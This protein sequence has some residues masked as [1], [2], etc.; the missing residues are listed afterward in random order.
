MGKVLPRIL[1]VLI[2]VF[3][4]TLPSGILCW[5]TLY[6]IGTERERIVEDLK[7]SYGEVLREVLSEAQ[8]WY[9]AVLDGFGEDELENYK[10]VRKT[11]GFV[12]ASIV[13]VGGKIVFPTSGLPYGEYP[14]ILG[15]YD[16]GAL[17]SLYEAERRRDVQGL[18][19]V[20]GTGDR[21]KREVA[22]FA[23]ARLDSGFRNQLSG[24][25][26]RLEGVVD[27]EAA[28]LYLKARYLSESGNKE[29]AAVISASLVNRLIQSTD[30]LTYSEI[31]YYVL[32]VR[33]LLEESRQVLGRILV[34]EIE[35][36]LERLDL[37]ERWAEK[38][39]IVKGERKVEKGI[40][41]VEK[42]NKQYWLFYNRDSYLREH[43]W[44]VLSGSFGGPVVVAM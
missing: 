44:R 42:G 23:L 8:K 40:V 9:V 10:K 26:E 6:F 1:P 35:S 37:M 25:V 13:T 3:V 24:E 12:E 43:I 4:I 32:F 22:K 41:E 27:A 11:S 14:G 16:Y 36:A 18:K 2:V 28:A 39:S 29:A 15:G 31:R 38:M 21:H 34:Q 7:R 5:L 30:K 20:L 19:N 17:Y 33:G